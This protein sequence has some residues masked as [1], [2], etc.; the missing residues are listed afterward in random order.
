MKKAI[1]SF[2]GAMMILSLAACTPTT[3]KNKTGEVKQTNGVADRR[4]DTTAPKLDVVSVYQV[5]EDGT[6]LTGTMEAV[7]EL[8]AQTL[9]DLLIEYGVLEEGTKIISFKEEGSIEEVGPSVIEIPGYEID[10]TMTDH[11]IL[12]LNQ[13]PDKYQ[14]KVI[15]AVANTFLENI[16]AVRMTL[17]VD[18]E[19]VREDL[20]LVDLS[21]SQ[22]EQK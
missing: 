7:E 10:N 4:P 16:H 8:N 18:G 11:I 20:S 17:K 22:S 21:E 2:I 13:L 12:D 14:D 6:K 3:E 5:S 9:V 15:E 19:T 1:M